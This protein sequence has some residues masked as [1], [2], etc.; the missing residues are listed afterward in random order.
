M[1]DF[2][3]RRGLSTEL[4]VDGELN[5]N[6]ILEEGCWYL[7][8]NTAE[9]FLG[10][11]DDSGELVLKQINHTDVVNRPSFAPDSGE[12]NE[13]AN[14]GIIGAYINDE[15]GELCLVFS[16]NTEESIG[17]VVGTDGKDGLTTSVKVGEVTYEQVNGIVELPNFTTK[18]DVDKKIGELTADITQVTEQLTQINQNIENIEGTYV[19]NETLEQN[20]ITQEEIANTYV[21]EEHVSTTYV[22]VQHAA[23]TYVTTEQ[24]TEVVTNEVN[25][26]VAEQIETK[27]ETVIQE[28]VDA[29][30]IAVKAESINYDTW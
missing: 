22:T 10:V 19:T 8:T 9:L 30:E 15:T 3:I 28:K 13:E 27:V 14:R 11:L 23:D 2:N 17:K 7:C 6:I 25:T 5:P 24:V 12:N 21:T 18:A 1:V 26:V 4:F 20:Y 16:D 29:G